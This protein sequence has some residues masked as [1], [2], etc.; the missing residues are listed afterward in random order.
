MKFLVAIAVCALV[1]VCAADSY[2]KPAYPAAPVA[3]TYAAHAP[4]VKCGANLLVGCAPNVA[5]VPCH[6]AHGG[7][8]EYHHAPAPAYH[9]A[10]APAYHAPAPAYHAPAKKEYHHAPAP[11]YHHAPAYEAKKEYA[12]PAYEA[13]KKEYGHHAAPP[14]HHGYEAKKPA[15]GGYGKRSSDFEA[16]ME[17]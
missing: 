7:H 14:M 8:Q 9:H 17:E 1:G 13:P 10:P 16:E 11:A 12:A 4:H 3:H 15:Y 5:H 6:P 2:G